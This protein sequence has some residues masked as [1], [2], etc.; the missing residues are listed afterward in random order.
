MKD[1]EVKQSFI[2]KFLTL[3]GNY[4]ETGYTNVNF[5]KNIFFNRP[6]DKIFFELNMIT[7]APEQIGVISDGYNE[8][9]TGIF[10]IDICV[11]LNSG[12]KETEDICNKL[13]E[14]FKVGT[15]FD[16]VTVNNVYKPTEGSE[17]TYYKTVVRVNFDADIINE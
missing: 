14:I 1:I 6:A 11:P 3:E 5:N 10:Q 4:F 16:D 17:K 7:N 8:R 2:K 15:T 12:M 9:I 13:F